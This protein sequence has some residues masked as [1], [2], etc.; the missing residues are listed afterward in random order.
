MIAKIE[1]QLVGGE[2]LKKAWSGQCQYCC[3]GR[4]VYTDA[5]KLEQKVLSRAVLQIVVLRVT[6]I[7]P[8]YFHFAHRHPHTTSQYYIYISAL[9]TTHIIRYYKEHQ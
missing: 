5:S 4:L 7:W 1:M 8:S 6:Q 3:E 2:C 9:S